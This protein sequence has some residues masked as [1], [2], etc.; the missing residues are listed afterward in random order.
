MAQPRSGTLEALAAAAPDQVVLREPATGRTRTRAEWD[1]QAGSLAV[2]LTDRFGIG[3][4]SRVAILL[5]HPQLELLDL[6]FALAKL[7]AV[8][9][10]LPGDADPQAARAQLV[11]RGAAATT[12]AGHELHVDRDLATLVRD[13]PGG[14]RPLSGFRAAP[15][16]VLASAGR[17]PRIWARDEGRVV[18]ADLA[19]VAGDLL[20]RAGHRQG[21]G[22]LLAA[23]PWLPA[24][25]LHANVTALAGG[26]VVIGPGDPAGWLTVLRDHE[27]GTAVLTPAMVAALL[28]LPQDELDDAD[29]TSLDAVIVAGDHLPVPHRLAAADL[30]G[31][32]S[33]APVYATAELGPVALLS[34]DAV[35]G[36][37]GTA[38]TPLQGLEVEIRDTDGQGAARGRPGRIHV[39]S[40]LCADG[41]GTAGDHGLR[42]AEGRLVVLGRAWPGWTDE[43]GTPVGPLAVRDALTGVPGVLD[44]AASAERAVVQ[45]RPGATLDR[46]ALLDAVRD[47][48][49]PSAAGALEIAVA[50]RLERDALGRP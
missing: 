10:L 42:D 6:V 16:T 4:G 5:D 15:V 7:G 33:V 26:E 44:A 17:P 14:P 39:R 40:P 32:D 13:A 18:H 41:A 20:I 48:V 38:G 29:T 21:R 25:L 47:R 12:G 45:A 28:A 49:G 11:V 34:R 23:P 27:P 37:P 36:D 1:A 3:H 35:T 9:V 24:A 22:H 30:F 50:D 2:A 46:A 43:D 31:E 19:T 8:P